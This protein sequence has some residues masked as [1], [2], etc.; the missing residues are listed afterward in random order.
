V[1]VE[2]EVVHESPVL[3]PVASSA[4]DAAAFSRLEVGG[5]A[6]DSLASMLGSPA[7]RDFDLDGVRSREAHRLRAVDD[8]RCFMRQKCAVAC[9]R[10]CARDTVGVPGELLFLSGADVPA[11]AFAAQYLRCISEPWS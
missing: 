2:Y 9:A 11:A 8:D 5:A 6:S 10:L 3:V 1:N 4:P 7:S